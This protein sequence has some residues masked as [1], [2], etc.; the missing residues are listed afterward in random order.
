[1]RLA[2]L[3]VRDFRNHGETEVQVPPGVVVAVG[4]NAQGKTNLLEA[5]HYLC[6]LESPRVASDQPLVRA[7]ADSAFLRGE[8]ETNAG[9]V[10]VEVEVRSSGANRIRVNGSGVR[11]KRDLRQ[12]VR[13]TMSI[14]EDLAVVQGEPEDRRRFLDQAAESMWP[15]TETARKSFERAVRQRNR[16]LKEHEGRGAPPGL[17]AWDAEVTTHGAALTAARGRAMERLAPRASEAYEQ[18][19]REPLH[20]GYAANVVGEDLEAAFTDRLAARREDELIRR[21]TLVGPHRDDVELAVGELTARRFASHG[22]SWAVALCLRLGL[23]DALAAEIEEPPVVLL[24]DPFSGLDPVRRARLGDRLAAREQVVLAVP[25][26]AQVPPG[27]TVWEVSDGAV[28]P[29]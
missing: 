15:V 9:R 13:S 2:W 11:R 18:V 27:A 12:R 5:A 17:D 10:L 8:I 3:E 26:E 23:A 1:M 29:R 6:T 24:D 22:E 14:P 20:V 19:A 21:R 7:G 4:P 25:D 16:L 28:R